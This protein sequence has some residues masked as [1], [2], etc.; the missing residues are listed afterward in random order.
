MQYWIK[1]LN[2]GIVRQSPL[3]PDMWGTWNGNNP[4]HAWVQYAW[5]QPVTLNETR[6]YFFNDQPAGSGIGVAPPKAWHLEYLKDGQWAPIAATYPTDM[7]RFNAVSFA[8]VTTTC[9][10]AVF[11]ASTK[12][13][14][15]AAV[16]VQEWEALAPDAQPVKVA[17]G[18]A[19]KGLPDEI[20]LSTAFKESVL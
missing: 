16:A 6:I 7:D 17:T 1:A 20:S 4:A 15:N 5:D 13:G 8:P 14:S 3:P 18:P 11:D 2:D 10:R 19:P 12:D 9:L